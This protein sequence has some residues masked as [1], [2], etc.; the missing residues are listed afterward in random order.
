MNWDRL[1]RARLGRLTLSLSPAGLLL[2]YL[3][4]LLHLGFSPGKQLDLARKSLRQGLRFAL[5]SMHAGFDK[6]T[7]PAIEPLPQDRRFTSPEWQ[8]WPFNLYYQSFLL[9]QQWLHSATTGVRG[10][11]RHDEQVINFVVRQLLDIFAPTNFPW[12]NPEVL[13]AS[14]EQGGNNFLRGITNFLE[15]WARTTLG[16][17]P[18][19]TEPFQVGKAVAI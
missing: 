9:A 19:G 6:G 11:T 15:D 8:K 10:V 14:V 18:V 4:W 1:L 12:T 7:P 17:R 3:D 2:I 5:Y 13:K 16:R